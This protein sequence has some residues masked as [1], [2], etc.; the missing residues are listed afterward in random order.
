MTAVERNSRVGELDEFFEDVC[1]CGETNRIVHNGF[2][3]C[4]NCGLEYEINFSEDEKRAFNNEEF[5][6][7]KRTQPVSKSY[8]HRTIVPKSRIDSKGNYLLPEIRYKI[9]RISKL[10]N[11]ALTTL[12]RNLTEANNPINSISSNLIIPPHVK[13]D[14]VKIYTKTAVKKLTR[15][16]SIDEFVVASFYTA[17]R[18]HRTPYFLEDL[19]NLVPSDKRNVNKYV[20]LINHYILPE[21]G[22]NYKVAS[23]SALIARISNDLKLPQMVQNKAVNCVKKALLNGLNLQGKD[24]KGVAGAALYLSKPDL[25]Q[26]DAASASRVTEV[27]LRT[28]AKELSKATKQGKALIEDELQE[29]DYSAALT[30]EEFLIAKTVYEKYLTGFKRVKSRGF[31]KSI[32]EA[33]IYN[34]FKDTDKELL[35]N[36]LL[37]TRK[38]D[39]K[40]ATESLQKTGALEFLLEQK[41]KL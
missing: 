29:E 40:Y 15:G 11:N 2:Y 23:I 38:C 30:H 4:S 12:E 9:F 41:K 35:I 3:V 39:M 10:N 8:G 16:R 37:I 25:T 34:L 36:T 19:T 21:M 33:V 7:R 20:R 13:E 17:F 27:T 32:F 18:I 31:S 24:P 14:A 26:R 28:R 6:N 5:K 22:V 1:E